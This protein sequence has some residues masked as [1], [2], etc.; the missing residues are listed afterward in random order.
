M[1]SLQLQTALW[2]QLTNHTVFLWQCLELHL[3][4]TTVILVLKVYCT[5]I[6][7]SF[8][9]H[10]LLFTLNACFSASSL[11]FIMASPVF[12][13]SSTASLCLIM[14]MEKLWR[15]KCAL[16]NVR[17][18]T[19][20]VFLWQRRLETTTWTHDW[21]SEPVVELW[22]APAQVWRPQH[23]TASSLPPSA[24]RAQWWLPAQTAH[25]GKSI[26][27]LC[28]SHFCTPYS[29]SCNSA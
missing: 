4:D 17:F 13:M 9:I 25:Q 12:T 15:R 2:I 23:K 5:Q 16:G 28:I 19:Y 10:F 24:T 22:Y 21:P 20:C 11:L 27:A 26:Q 18:I 3:Y 8:L 1:S 7:I 6:R 14:S 29:I